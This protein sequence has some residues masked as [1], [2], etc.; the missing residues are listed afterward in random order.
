MGI[1][2][3]LLE[4]LILEPPYS[5]KS[6]RIFILGSQSCSQYTSTQLGLF[7]FFHCLIARFQ[8][9]TN[10]PQPLTLLPYTVESENMRCGRSAVRNAKCL[11]SSVLSAEALRWRY[12]VGDRHRRQPCAI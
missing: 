4:F 11:V 2:K 8:G 1:A 9:S 3:N 5:D 10:G 7:V 12:F 6:T